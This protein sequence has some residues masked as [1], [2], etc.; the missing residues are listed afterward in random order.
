[1]KP[2]NSLAR[3]HGLIREGNI[4]VPRPAFQKKKGLR[5]ANLLIL[6]ARATDAPQEQWQ[7][8]LPENVPEIVRDP[9]AINSFIS[10][11]TMETEGD[12]GIWFWRAEEIIEEAH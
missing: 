11:M 3:G 2:D 5:S 10:G 6:R 9:E 4:I 1:M 12:D 8:V 7:I